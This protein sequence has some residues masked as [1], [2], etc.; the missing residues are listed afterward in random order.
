M[1]RYKIFLILLLLTLI[2]ILG[3]RYRFRGYESFPPISDNFDEQVLVWVG[4]SLINNGV[5]TA[6]SFIDDY[7]KEPEAHTIGWGLSLDNTKP[8]F[9]NFSSFPKPL[10]HKVQMTLDGYTTQFTLVQPHIEQ[11][12]LGPMLA[13]FLSGSFQ[14]SGFDQISLKQIR[15]PVIWLSAVTMILIF[16]IGFLSNGIEVGLFGALVFALMPTAVISS[17]LAT[18]ENYLTPFILL[19]VFFIQLWILKNQKKYLILASILVTVCYLIKPFGIS[20]AGVLFLAIL[21]FNKPPKFLLFPII[22]AILGMIIFLLYGYFY[23][24]LLFPKIFSY[25]TSRLF[26]PLEGLFKILIPKITKVFLDGWV[27]FGWISAFAL[28]LRNELKKDFWVLAPLLCYVLILTLYGGQDYGWYRI[29]IYPYLS[30][31]AAIIL[32]QAI[33][34]SNPFISI[35]F[36]MIVFTGS[37]WWAFFGLSWST[38]VA[39]PFRLFM[40]VAILLLSLGFLRSLRMKKISAWTLVILMIVTFWLNIQTINNTQLIWPTLREITLVWSSNNR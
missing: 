10:F 27:V 31:A 38:V 36:L 19:G 4:S 5:P 14:K 21:T 37:L 9:S 15:V 1:T 40:V 8:G 6:W 11:P 12:P 39:L 20:L 22:S 16:S 26:S 33:K 2:V 29:P 13:S 24:P 18:A 25:Q 34:Y 23:A 3:L 17:R 30:L 32:I 7:V 28:L 35:I